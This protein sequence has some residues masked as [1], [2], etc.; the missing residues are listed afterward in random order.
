[1]DLQRIGLNPAGQPA[2]LTRQV[3]LALVA[4]GLVPVNGDFQDFAESQGLL[5]QFRDAGDSCRPALPGRSAHRNISRI[6]FS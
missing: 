5:D 1:M 4:N 2:R 6:V 3:N